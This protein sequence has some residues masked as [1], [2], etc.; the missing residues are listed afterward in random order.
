MYKRHTV[1]VI[2]PAYNEEKR[3]INIL[4]LL[5][6][7]DFIDEI[8][9]V[10]DGSTDQTPNLI[11]KFDTIKKINLKKNHGKG[12]AV[13]A[14]IKK[15]KSEIIVLI[16]ADLLHLKVLHIEKLIK[17]LINYKY[18]ASIGYPIFYSIDHLLKPIS[19]ERAYFKKDLIPY[20]KEIRHKGYGLELYLNYIFRNKRTKIF[21]LNGVKNILKHNKQSLDIAAKLFLIEILD[22][23]G[24]VSKQKNPFLYLNNSYLESFYFHKSNSEKK[25]NINKFFRDIR[26]YFLKIIE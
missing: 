22:I 11:N 24:E 18:E 23:F 10:N 1:A 4:S 14:G 17:S 7:C 20:L 2:V 21:P 3:I 19:G 12:F 16:D 5:S 8:I 25:L 9:V 15:A 26:R 13:A 6:R